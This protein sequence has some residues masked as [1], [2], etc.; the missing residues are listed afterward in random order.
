MKKVLILITILISTS[1][2][3]QDQLYKV[4]LLR[5]KPGELLNL[6]NLL[7]QDIANYESYLEN[8]PYLLRHSQGDHWDLMLIYPID[9]LE[10]Y[11]TKTATDRRANSRTFE[12]EH[13]SDFFQIVSFQEEAIVK[14]PPINSFIDAFEK[15]EL[16]HIEIFTALAGKQSELLEQRLAE[17]QYYAGIEHRPNFIFTRVFG[18]SWDNFTIGFYEDMHDFAGPE[19]TFETEDQAA[20]EAGFDGVNYI[21][22][23]LRSL[24][25]EHHDTLAWKVD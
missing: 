13:A 25:A 11:F 1:I 12:K 10:S 2:V 3:A 22:S 6:I 19:I 14:G 17:N 9:E 21:G 4:T 5:A 24:I 15:Y 23:Y 18:P 8:K 20:K 16:F 7:D